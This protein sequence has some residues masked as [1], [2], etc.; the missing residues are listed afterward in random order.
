MGCIYRSPSKHFSS[1]ADKELITSIRS[2]RFLVDSRKN[3]GVLI[4]GN[5]NLPNISWPESH[6]AF[7][8]SA[9]T[10]SE[11]SIITALDDC[12]M[13][14]MVD[15]PTFQQDHGHLTSTL[16]L[17]LSNDPHRIRKLN[18]MPPLGNLRKAHVGLTWQLLTKE[19]NS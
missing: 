18:C 14:Q 17:I 3:D 4:A 11:E 15:F 7:A 10:K 1:E 19:S 9:A 8:G 5:F 12:F 16:D 2:S 6:I 13:H